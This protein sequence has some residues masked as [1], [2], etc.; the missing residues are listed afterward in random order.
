M[1][2][3]AIHD[4]RVRLFVALELPEPVRD[5]LIRWRDDVTGQA[6]R[7]DVTGQ[8]RAL[9]WLDSDSLH[10]TMCFLGWRSPGELGVIAGA[11]RVLAGA[12]AGAGAARLSLGAP[13]WLPPRRPRV[14]A[15]EVEDPDGSITRAQAA[16]SRALAA[17]GWYEPERRRYLPH[18]TV[19]RVARGGRAPRGG[20]P[21]ISPLEFD[22]ERVTLFRSRLSRVGA[23]YEP[24]ASIELACS[25]R[26]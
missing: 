7:D 10:V 1:Q 3:P 16:L 18:V 2:S 14:L 20:P 26:P 21:R 12:G 11:M 24:L 15:V 23:R 8:A 19:A 6:R 13:V 5:A 25:R 17:G 4:E 9:R 22:G